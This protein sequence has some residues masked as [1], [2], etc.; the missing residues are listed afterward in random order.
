MLSSL[1]AVALLQLFFRQCAIIIILIIILIIRLDLYPSPKPQWSTPPSLSIS[2]ASRH[3]TRLAASS[4][5]SPSFCRAARARRPSPS[6]SPRAPS[7]TPPPST[8]SSR[9][10]GPSPAPRGLPRPSPSSEPTRGSCARHRR[11]CRPRPT[12][13]APSTLASC[14]PARTSRSPALRRRCGSKI[15]KLWSCPPCRR[16]TTVPPTTATIQ[17]TTCA[18]PSRRTRTPR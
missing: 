1:Y 16:T 18:R 3:L 13:S 17:S 5:N 8:R 6:T 11:R 10:F 14:A 15:S 2:L 7:P 9:R 12:P 4:C